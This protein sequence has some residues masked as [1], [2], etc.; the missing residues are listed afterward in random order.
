VGKLHGP[1]QI[2]V[3][4]SSVPV[5]LAPNQYS[6]FPYLFSF[7]DVNLALGGQRGSTTAFLGKCRRN[8]SFSPKER[9]M[10]HNLSKYC[11][12]SLKRPHARLSYLVPVE[13]LRALFKAKAFGRRFSHRIAA[14][15][16]AVNTW[17]Q[18]QTTPLFSCSTSSS[19]SIRISNTQQDDVTMIDA[20]EH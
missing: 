4:Y 12:V 5:T 6:T 1:L 20:S 9:T 7:A 8:S 16:A 2:S 10:F 19:S 3:Y 14:V 18:S 13:P 11:T 17:L 15:S